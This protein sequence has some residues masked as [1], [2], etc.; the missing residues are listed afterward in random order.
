MNIVVCVICVVLMVFG[1]AELT[2]VLV[3][4][5]QK[6]LTSRGF[7]LVVEPR[8]AEECECTLRAAAERLRW[9]DCKGPCRLVCVN[10]RGDPEIDS[11]CRFLMLRYPF[12]RVCK[13]EE[14]VYNLQERED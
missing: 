14:V 9:L 12:L 8:N 2:R 11:I 10:R 7:L 1:V 3:F 5:W 4:W 13:A 6:P